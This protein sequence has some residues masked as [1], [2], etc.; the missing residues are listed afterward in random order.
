MNTSD[1]A[2]F[3]A[4]INSKIA[5]HLDQARRALSGADVFDVTNV[6]ALADLL[7]Q[8]EPHVKALRLPNAEVSHELALQMDVYTKQLRG[9][10]KTVE[11]VRMMLL[12]R[13]GELEFSHRHMFAVARW[14][15]AYQQ[16]R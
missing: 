11:Q 6:Q 8:M 9:L 2:A 14:T 10:G 12:A 15:S 3:V 7:S 1:R 16:T 13:R 5:V 4:E